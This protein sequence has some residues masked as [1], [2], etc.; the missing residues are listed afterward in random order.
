MWADK[1]F[2]LADILTSVNYS[3]LLTSHYSDGVLQFPYS[4]LNPD[5]WRLISASAELWNTFLYSISAVYFAPVF[6]FF[7]SVVK[8]GQNHFTASMDQSNDYTDQGLVQSTYGLRVNTPHYKSWCSKWNYF[9]WAESSER[10]CSAHRTNN[11][12][13]N[14]LQRSTERVNRLLW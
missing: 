12:G 1:L 10:G 9:N 14:K 8:L 3:S 4:W 13:H 5:C 6:F 7:C 2:K 11:N